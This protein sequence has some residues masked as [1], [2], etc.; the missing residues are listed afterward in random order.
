VPSTSSRSTAAER[1][2]RREAR[3]RRR[4]RNR[5]IK[6]AAVILAVPLVLI[7]LWL[8]AR[9]LQARGE[10]VAAANGIGRVRELLVAGQPEAAEREL[11][12]VRGHTARARYYTDDPVWRLVGAVPVLGRN[13]QTVSGVAAV[14]DDLAAGTLPPLLDTAEALSPDRLR[15]AGD[16]IALAPLVE[17]REP[18]GVARGNV[19]AVWARA[20]DLPSSLLLPPVGSARGS[21][22]EDLEGLRNVVTRA[23]AAAELLPSMLGGEGQR[24]YFVG[25]QTPA[26]LRGT[27]GLVG[28]YGILEAENGQVRLAELGS[29]RE[30]PRLAEPVIDLGPEFAERYQGWRSL[31]Q[32]NNA[33][34]T[35]HFPYVG[36]LWGAFWEEQRGE[37]VDGVLAVDPL[38]L[39][40]LLAAT[41]PVT[42]E[43]GD[44]VTAENVA[45]VT[46]VDNYADYLADG[47]QRNPERK[48][49]LV[50]IAEQSYD[51]ITDDQTDAT[52]LGA[53]LV[54]AVGEERVRVYS[55]RPEEQAA[56]DEFGL[57][58]A[59]PAGPGPYLQ[60]VVNSDRAGKMDYY[61][62]REVVYR[63]GGCN[64]GERE[65][66]VAVRLTN[67]L[68]REQAAGLPPYVVNPDTPLAGQNRSFL[69]VYATP[70]AGLRGAELDGEIEPME[71]AEEAGHPVFATYFDIEPGQTR[72]LR[73]RLLEPA[74]PGEPV[75][76]SQPMAF[77]GETT[78]DVA[79]C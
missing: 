57:S 22:L 65:T 29:N 47:T 70:G 71:I 77:A 32:W 69:S 76:D 60:A 36:Q 55:T 34:V 17:A 1:E 73:L 67:T 72:E 23:A 6:T 15:T 61:L 40:H 39:G 2:A 46:M 25:F 54:D 18:L 14:A 21:L 20:Q 52:A 75:V 4:R 42:L 11:L 38:V 30:L 62:R 28:A 45:Q 56:L 51:R 64:D 58:G 74:A 41:G 48:D 12:E 9:G 3:R 16:T 33:N 44:T 79:T 43:N 10:L 68:T 78:V 7:G 66:E 59:L 27:G 50:D 63:G 31:T 13:A 49:F 53:G 5:R 35:A 24:R 19:D 8:A 37:A 26:E